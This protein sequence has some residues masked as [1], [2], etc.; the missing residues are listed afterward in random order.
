MVGEDGIV[1]VVGKERENEEKDTKVMSVMN[2]DGAIFS[3]CNDEQIKAIAFVCVC[4][5]VVVSLSFSL[6]IRVQFVL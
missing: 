3:Y 1:F 2:K 5:C 6:L 4:V